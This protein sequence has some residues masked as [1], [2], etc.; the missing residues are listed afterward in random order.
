MKCNDGT[1]PWIG[2]PP[3]LNIFTI[4]HLINL[5]LWNFQ[6]LLALSC[7]TFSEKIMILQ[8]KI[9]TVY[10][11]TGDLLI[12]IFFQENI[13]QKYI[14]G[15]RKISSRISFCISIRNIHWKNYQNWDINKVM[16]VIEIMWNL[17]EMRKNLF[18][19]FGKIFIKNLWLAIEQIP[20]AFS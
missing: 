1:T 18:R 9:I 7:Y 10:L 6:A 15:F 20:L 14:F 3:E 19:S 5:G 11:V 8:W 12:Y 17:F 2:Y 4:N 13:Q 16:S